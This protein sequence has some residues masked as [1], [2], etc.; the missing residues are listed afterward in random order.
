MTSARKNP[1]SLWG[2]GALWRLPPGLLSESLLPD[3][4][5]WW[6]AV[7][8]HIA[9]YVF[10][11][12]FVQGRAVLD[13]A[14]GCG[15]GSAYL[16]SRGA[17]WVVGGDISEKAIRSARQWLGNGPRL[18]FIFLNGTQLPFLP[19]SFDLVVSF[20]TIEHLP[21]P[22]KFL[23]EVKRVLKPGGLFLCS[24]PNSEVSPL[25]GGKP[26]CAY[27]SQEFT[28]PGFHSLIGEYFAISA[29][30]GQL[31]YHQLLPLNISRLW[32]RFKGFLLR[33]GKPALTL[34]LGLFLG[35][36]SQF[37][38]AES[39]AVRLRDIPFQDYEKVTSDRVKPFVLDGGQGLKAGNL[40]ILAK[41]PEEKGAEGK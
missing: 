33:R 36:F 6:G 27:H 35:L 31:L 9:R 21:A 15:Y 29:N 14:C 19:R 2:P 37:F 40:M 18:Q 28:A 4:L 10:A 23:Q 11:A 7:Q 17:R 41:V 39:H 32:F 1:L 22:R 24:T 25:L 16:L 8:E 5:N 20:E 30:Y 12:Q 3:Q 38:Q 34:R 26:A 13:V